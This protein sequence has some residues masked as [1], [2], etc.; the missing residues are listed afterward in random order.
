MVTCDC[1]ASYCNYRI[2]QIV[3]RIRKFKDREQKKSDR[4]KM[5]QIIEKLNHRQGLK[6]NISLIWREH[7]TTAQ[8]F[9]KKTDDFTKVARRTIRLAI[10]VGFFIVFFAAGVG[11]ECYNQRRKNKDE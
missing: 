10:G 5:E 2:D 6:A 1:F 9:V 7:N 11:Y 3:K 8:R 4:D